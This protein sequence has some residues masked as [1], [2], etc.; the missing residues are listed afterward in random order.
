MRFP[1]V[2]TAAR[3]VAA[4]GAVA[5]LLSMGVLGAQ[6]APEGAGPPPGDPAT[7]TTVGGV[8][9]SVA[10]ERRDTVLPK[11]WRTSADTAWT[12]SGDATGLHVLVATA[13]S[14]YTWQTAATLAEPGFDTDMW[15][16]NA[17]LTGSGRRLVVAYAPRTFTNKADLFD[18]GA[19]TAVVD[20]QTGAVRKLSVQS[21]LAYFNPGCGAG[22]TAVISQFGGDR[23]DDPAPTA[24]RS[25]LFT[26]DS[27][28][29]KL[30]TPIG[31]R[32]EV[33]SAVPTSDG[34]V[35]AGPGRLVRVGTD[36]TTKPL[37]PTTGV[38]F[39]LVPDGSGQVTFAE[40]DGVKVRVR[41]TSTA[42]A[43][44]AAL[45]A[46]GDL[47]E[48][49]LT[50]GANGK[51]FVT[52]RPTRVAALPGS[53]RV[54]DVPV[55][56]EPS[57][58]GALALTRVSV[59]AGVD[60][61]LAVDPQAGARTVTVQAKV[62][63]GGAR[64]DFRV[65]PHVS[66]ANAAAGTAVNPLLL[67]AA[68]AGAGLRLKTATTT[69]SAD[70]PVD[71][72]RYCSVPRND[73]RNQAMQP[74]PRQVEWAVDQAIT[75]SLHLARPA[76]WKNLGMPAY[77]PQGLFP[78]IPL[79]GGGR[80][81]A[82]IMLG[83]IAQESNMWQASRFALPGVTANPLIGNFYGRE[84]YNANPDDDW[85]INWTKSDCG[86]GLT[87]VTD[88]MRL[89]GHEKGP[90]DTA[91][92][93]QTQRAVAL[94]FATNIAAGLRILQDK[95][96]QTRQGGLMIHDGNPAALENWFFA[97][98]AYNS[99]YHPQSEAAANNGAWGVGWGNNPINPRFNPQRKAFLEVSY[100]DA[101]NPQ[102]WPY[103]EKIMGWAGHPIEASETPETTV[104]GYRAAWWTTAEAR[105]SV[106]PPLTKFCDAT[107]DCVPGALF[108]PNEEDVVGEP[109][110][111]CG[112]I[113]DAGWYDLKC[114]FNRPVGWQTDPGASCSRCGNEVLRFD[115]GY[116]YQD[117]GTSFPPR[118]D[119]TGLP[120]GAR[121]VDDV[122][123]DIRSVRTGCPRNFTNA[124]TFALD[125]AGDSAGNRP[126]KIDFHQVGAGF[127]GHLWRAYTRV[128]GANG[129][130][131]KV[132]GTWSASQAINGWT[133]I[134]VSVPDHGAWTRQAKYVVNLGNGQT[135]Y[136]VVNQAWREHRWI[137]LGVFPVNGKPSVSLSTE[138]SDGRGEDA[139]IFDAVAFV[140]T[141][142][143]SAI[144]VAMGDSYSSG[145][146]AAPYD[147]N[148]DYLHTV[149][150]G[151]DKNACHRSR[152]DAYPRKVTLPGHAAPIAQEAAEGK[153]SFGFIA[154]SGAMTVSL[155]RDAVNNPPTAD[156][157]RGSTS[158]G[159][160]DQHFGE[161]AQVDQGYLD[162]DTTLV[163]VSI[164]GNDARFGDVLNGCVMTL[165]NCYDSDYRLTR[166]VHG[167]D[168]VDPAPLKDYQSNLIRN[169]LPQHLKAVYRAIRAK[170]PNAKILVMGYP[171]MFPNLPS[172]GCYNLGP[173]TQSF[174]NSLA[175]LLTTTIA[176]AVQEVKDEGANIRFVEPNTTWLVGVG[177]NSH[178]ACPATP[179][180]WLNALTATSTTG[181]G[182]ATPGAG[183][184]HPTVAGYRAYADLANSALQGYSHRAMVSQ[185]IFNYVASRSS[186]GWQITQAQADEA[187]LRCLNLAARSG[188]TGDP[189]M[190]VPILFPTATDANG[191]AINDDDAIIGNPQWLLNRYVSGA[192][193]EAVLSRSW[194]NL[195]GVGQTTCPTPRP[196][197]YQCDEYPFYSSERG[198]VWDMFYG[199][200]STN[201]TRLRLVPTAEN[202][203]EGTMLGAMYTKCQMTSGTYEPTQGTLKTHGQ[204]YLTIP[205]LFSP[206]KTFYVC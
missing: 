152:D 162:V 121:I 182:S 187:A 106:K 107:N 194:M 119:L 7:V 82:Q 191:A 153:A 77:T 46:E 6:A 42:T 105:A 57:S 165:G 19:F 86:Y 5:L 143:P 39:R 195:V 122:A 190:S 189:C 13:R 2:R 75:N 177:Q 44:P 179:N 94:D 85:A 201:S 148:S 17:C 66:G 197:G 158:W 149:S 109:A 96:N 146:G 9:N 111:P 147:R 37:A 145:E 98:W 18:R 80:V 181:S 95:W 144:Y 51:A 186:D 78:S 56:S 160:A 67:G 129:G 199:E 169:Q 200:T 76:D 15:I 155:T 79:I 72:E 43:A 150:D 45:L 91:W 52:G 25:R 118:C 114:W 137:D 90:D 168:V 81:P 180:S 120:A 112:H 68:P 203:A 69:S 4:T 65:G 100:D 136:R 128:Q 24:I 124:G 142:A 58:T 71:A 170:A 184:F 74:K 89:A 151:E 34:I 32:T 117:D 131:L 87:Q 206:P 33:T 61:R 12:T 104:A 97:V 198:G 30:S 29:G 73:P 83:I 27:A 132:T 38:A 166:D 138:T 60:P 157:L 31:L 174:L 23:A 172:E 110:G 101:R 62:L 185:R 188:L 108:P 35:A 141:Q 28:T 204:P 175:G 36:G 161:V 159:A 47:T 55:G 40:H 99:G 41:H 63:A 133:R 21:S 135:R 173:Q 139:I 113:D 8:T 10:A 123:D 54:L 50:R 134:M 93:Y 140:P 202:R 88:H 53:V 59:A 164:G 22:E 125:F 178:A 167:T 103:P 14:G 115:P 156:D 11:G 126:S 127:G 205:L 16:G 163:T 130:S 176:K 116:A 102:W 49:G 1:V 64:L 70:N 192:Q 193:K 20:L 183:S 196:T 154:C 48:L 84:I 3:I 171:Q 26:V 92:T